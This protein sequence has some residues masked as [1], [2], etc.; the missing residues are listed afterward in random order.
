[1]IRI[2]CPAGDE[3]VCLYAAQFIDLFKEAGWI[4]DGGVVH[5]ITLGIPHAGVVLGS[6]V[7]APFDPNAK[8]GTG[9]WVQTTPSLVSLQQAFA[10]IRI[11]TLGNAAAEIPKNRVEVYFGP[12]AS[13]DEAKENLRRSLAMLKI[14]RQKAVVPKPNQ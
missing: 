3:T 5:R 1:V 14:L 11:G 4:V 7:D 13:P 10:N 2:D 8:A 6:H 12:E 9:R